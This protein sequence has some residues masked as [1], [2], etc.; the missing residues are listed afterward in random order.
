MSASQ[1]QRW[2]VFLSGFDYEIKHVKGTD[3]EVADCLSRLNNKQVQEAIESSKVLKKVRQYVKY[4]WP[5]KV[6]DELAKFKNKELELSIENDCLMWG[7]RLVVPESLRVLMLRELHDGH[8][9]VV[10]MKALARSYIR[11]PGMDVEIEKIT[12]PCEAYLKYNDSPPK[13]K[14]HVWDWPDAPNVCLHADF[15]GPLDRK[16]YL[17]VVDIHSKWVDVKL[18]HDITLKSTIYA[19]REY[20]ADWGL[21]NNGVLHATLSHYHPA[22]NGVAEN[23]VKTFKKKCKSFRGEDRSRKESLSKYLFHV[24]ITPHVTTGVSQAELQ[25]GRKMRTRWDL[26]RESS[27]KKVQRSQKAQEKFFHETRNIAFEDNEIVMAKDY[28]NNS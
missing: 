5:S 22:S 15:L 2:A 3:N 19:F 12:K 18:M 14:L 24:R 26:L 7:H 25:L 10:K 9:G 6:N 20:F 21:P 1:L 27:R 17:I 13:S 23:A 8:M 16:M 4:G 28:R 11:W